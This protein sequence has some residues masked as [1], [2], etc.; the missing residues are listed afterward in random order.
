MLIIWTRLLG[1][2]R[3]GVVRESNP[4]LSTRFF[5]R[6]FSAASGK[7][8]LQWRKLTKPFDFGYRR[9]THKKVSFSYR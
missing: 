8:S 3:V 4:L 5:A 2:K 6:S 7:R 9:L 1:I